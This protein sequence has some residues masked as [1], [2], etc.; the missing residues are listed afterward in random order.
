MAPNSS[1]KTPATSLISVIYMA[2]LQLFGDLLLPSV[3]LNSFFFTFYSCEHKMGLSIIA[4][5]LMKLSYSSPIFL[6]GCKQKT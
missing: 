2:L 4:I 6:E 5:F 1:A 3:Y